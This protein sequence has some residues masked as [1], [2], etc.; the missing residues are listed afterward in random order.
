MVEFTINNLIILADSD[1]NAAQEYS[2]EHYSWKRVLLKDI[3]SINS[4]IEL[5]DETIMIYG[6]RMCSKILQ[7]FGCKIALLTADFTKSLEAGTS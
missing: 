1:L 4:K 5:K 3:N 6:F 2:E 7:K